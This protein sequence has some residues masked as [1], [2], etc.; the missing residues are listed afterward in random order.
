MKEIVT[1]SQTDM[2]IVA[3]A[4]LGLLIAAIAFVR[5]KGRGENGVVAGILWGGPLLLMAVLWPLYNALTDGLGLDSTSNLA[6]NL[7]LFVIVGIG[8][9]IIGLRLTK[10]RPPTP[11]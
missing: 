1:R 6:A 8:A 10:Q 7:A 9:G 2:V 11:R 5:A 3:V 4:V